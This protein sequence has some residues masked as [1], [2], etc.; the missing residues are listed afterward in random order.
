[1]GRPLTPTTFL[2][3][4][5][6]GSNLD[7]DRFRCYLHGGRPLGA[8]RTYPGCREPADPIDVQPFR[9]RGQLVFAWESPTWGGGIAFHDPQ[10]PGEVL[11][12]AYLLTERQLTDVLEQEMRREPGTDHDLAL[13]RENGHHVLGPGRYE[14]I[15][16]VGTLD[17]RPVVTF[18]GPD[19]RALGVRAPAPAYVATIARG[20]R[21]T[22][23]LTDAEIASY[24]LDCP[25][26]RPEW[27]REGLLDLAHR[28]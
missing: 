7:A 3:Y 26:V 4:A 27:T 8:T 24:L 13:L 6:Y 15:R 2:W 28:V 9:M 20:L 12:R 17:D 21:A 5:G 16:V 25:G 10:G 23:G 14:T 19:P 18:G 11:A 22:H 1:L